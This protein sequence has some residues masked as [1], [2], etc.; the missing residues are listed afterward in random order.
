MKPLMLTLFVPIFCL[1]QTGSEPK[2]R[3][4]S[5]DSIPNTA[6]TLK[7]KNVIY[8][9]VFLSD[10]KK[11]DL[12]D[13]INMLLGNMRNFKFNKDNYLSSFDFF[14]RLSNYKFSLNKFQ[15]SWFER[16][17]ILSCPM[18]ASVAIQ[19][20]DY[21]YRVT[22]SEMTIEVGRDTIGKTTEIFFDD[23]IT[24]RNRTAFKMSKSNV[25]TAER[26]NQDFADRFN[27]NRSA[28]S[29]DF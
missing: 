18:N 21:K 16:P 14:G 4:S 28:I 7:D 29:E 15:S 27:L 12:A 1:V 11:E 8:Q 10:L 9:K 22:I 20:K 25:R 24:T 2:T 19:V 3:L 26:V 17:T 5:Q 13:R 23:I 6:I